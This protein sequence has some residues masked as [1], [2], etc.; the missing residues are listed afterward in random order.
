M[1]G[2]N[3]VVGWGGNLEQSGPEHKHSY[4]VRCDQCL[5]KSG[6]LG[7][8]LLHVYTDLES[9]GDRTSKHDH[10]Q[11]HDQRMRESSVAVDLDDGSMGIRFAFGPYKNAGAG[12]RKV[13]NF[14]PSCSKESGG[15][16]N[17]SQCCNQ[18]M[19]ARINR[20]ICVCIFD[21]HSHGAK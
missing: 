21:G 11:C 2:T 5:S 7:S 4:L 19:V 16:H 17:Y 10:F 1:R 6:C 20:A 8:S 13:S 15:K 3:V 12:S 14:C 9:M 18:C